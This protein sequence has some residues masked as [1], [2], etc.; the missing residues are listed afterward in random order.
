MKNTKKI[1]KLTETQLNF[2]KKFMQGVEIIEI[3]TELGINSNLVT[4]WMIKSP[5]F[6]S[7]LNSAV[8]LKERSIF[9][10]NLNLRTKCLEVLSKKADANDLKAVELALKNLEIEPE[11]LLEQISPTKL[12]KKM[13]QEA[14]RYL[15]PGPE[16]K[17]KRDWPRGDD[18]APF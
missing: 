11:F 14:L 9:V 4:G 2:I 5:L 8:Y 16:F 3:M 7:S 15:D 6:A 1:E 10:K 18:D 17:R 13:N 12:K